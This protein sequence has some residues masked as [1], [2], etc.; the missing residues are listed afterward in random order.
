MENTLYLYETLV[1]MLRQHRKWLDL[2]HLQTLAWLMGG[3]LH[4]RAIS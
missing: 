3:L 4:S 2:R 1:Q